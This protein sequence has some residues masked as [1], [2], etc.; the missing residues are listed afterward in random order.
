MAIAKKLKTIANAIGKLLPHVAAILEGVV[1]IT[2][3]IRANSLAHVSVRKKDGT[4]QN[5]VLS[6][7]DLAA[8]AKAGVKVNVTDLR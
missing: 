7:D 1:E 4:A 5:L 8:A 2:G 3:E 6:A